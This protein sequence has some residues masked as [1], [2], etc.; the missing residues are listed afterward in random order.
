MTRSALLAVAL[1]LTSSAGTTVLL[2]VAHAGPEGTDSGQLPGYT[3]PFANNAHLTPAQVAAWPAERLPYLRNEIYARYGRPFKNA[4]LRAHF[5]SQPWYREVPTYADHQLTPAD[6]ANAKL[7]RSF[8][9]DSP[10]RKYQVGRLYFADATSLV[11]SDDP[12][13]YGFV[14]K[15]RHYVSRGA[16]HVITWTGSKTFDLRDPSVRDAE[17]WTW[18]GADWTNVPIQRPSM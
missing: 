7:I 6:Q 15:E 17:L 18:T 1:L 11:I 10:S 12:S 13:F 8:E 3:G 2:P 4:K 5:M 9:G 16:N 14:G